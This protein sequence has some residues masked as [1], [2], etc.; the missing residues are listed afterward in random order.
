[1][2]SGISSRRDMITRTKTGDS[3]FQYD[4]SL[5]KYTSFKTGGIA[6]IFV[7]P[8][9]V[10]ELREVLRFCMREQKRFLYW[11]MEP[12]FSFRTMG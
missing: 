8:K 4:I 5:R 2:V 3:I 6:E 12:T 7:E 9:S 10:S 1:M 11:E